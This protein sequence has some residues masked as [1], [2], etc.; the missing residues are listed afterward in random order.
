MKKEDIIKN[1]HLQNRKGKGIILIIILIFFTACLNKTI[2]EKYG[3][4][5]NKHRKAVGLNRLPENWIKHPKTDSGR[6]W[7]TLP[8]DSNEIIKKAA[9]LEKVSFII[10]DSLISETDV[11]ISPQ[12]CFSLSKERNISLLYTYYFFDYD[13]FK[14]GWTYFFNDCSENANLYGYISKAKADSILFSWKLSHP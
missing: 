6:I 5:F 4:G 14:T 8:L 3:I 12:K 7:W 9:F 10:N 13:E 2:E 1:I 11:Y